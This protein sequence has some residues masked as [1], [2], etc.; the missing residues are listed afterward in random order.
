M[1][2]AVAM[3]A[4]AAH[5]LLSPCSS[6]LQPSPN[7]GCKCPSRVCLPWRLRPTRARM[8]P[9]DW[10]VY[11]CVGVRDALFLIRMQYVCQDACSETGCNSHQTPGLRSFFC[12]PSVM[13]LC[14][15]AVQSQSRILC[16]AISQLI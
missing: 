7:S 11:E 13:M 3:V 5:F 12:F 2:L 9:S 4:A 1:L 14:T 8:P 15:L 10:L 16:I 6:C